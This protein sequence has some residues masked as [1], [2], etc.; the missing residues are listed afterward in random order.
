MA[1]QMNEC[2]QFELE[3]QQAMDLRLP[4]RELCGDHPHLESCAVCRGLL[5]DFVRLD[6]SLAT[7]CAVGRVREMDPVV[8]RFGVLGREPVLES[9]RGT[10]RR[11]R[12]ARA[13]IVPKAMA[14][15]VAL[16]VALAAISPNGPAHAPRGFSSAPRLN[17]EASGGLGFSGGLLLAGGSGQLVRKDLLDELGAEGAGLT[18]AQH[19]GT[20]APKSIVSCLWIADQFPGVPPIRRSAA[21]T[22]EWIRQAI[23]APPQLPPLPGWLPDFSQQAVPQHLL[24]A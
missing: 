20:S 5:E 10:P 8:S 19:P 24:V 13:A 7:L 22:I 18:Q 6:D 4:P 14:F 11:Q 9:R 1:Q 15:T 2:R 12:W 21:T 17:P 23:P 3:L 16:L